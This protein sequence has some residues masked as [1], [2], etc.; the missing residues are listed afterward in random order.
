[1]KEKVKAKQEKYNALV[2]SR[3][4]EEKEEN[5]VHYRIAK[6][7]GKKVV[8]VTKNNAYE[9]LYQRLHSKEGEKEVFKLARAKER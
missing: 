3:T 4:D 9:R 1:M 5:R 7:E 2:G 6:R 8:A